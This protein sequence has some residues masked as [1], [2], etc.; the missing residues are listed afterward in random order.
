METIEPK[1]DK[2]VSY[3]NQNTELYPEYE[4]LWEANVPDC[5][6]SPTIDGESIRVIG[7]LYYEWCNNGNCNA[8]EQEYMDCPECDGSGWEEGEEEETDCYYCDGYCRVEG[9][10]FISEYYDEMLDHIKSHV[11]NSSEEVKAVRELILTKNEYN[12]DQKECDV[13]NALSDK[14]VKHVMSKKENYNPK[15]KDKKD[16]KELTPAEPQEGYRFA[17]EE[18][19]K[20]LEYLNSLRKSGQTNMFGAAPYIQKYMG[21]DT[22]ESNRLL[23]L[24]MDNFNEECKYSQVK[25]IP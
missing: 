4:K 25:C 5:G 15:N 2:V 19:K 6:E 12:F 17:T 14:V 16:E 20:A 22:K 23:Q 1:V 18:E 8:I 13:Y 10:R 3:W 7:R 24:W 11:P 9:E 21:V